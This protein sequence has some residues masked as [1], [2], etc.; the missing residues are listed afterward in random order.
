MINPNIANPQLRKCHVS[1]LNTL[2]MAAGRLSYP[3]L[4]KPSKMPGDSDDKAKYSTAILIP[5]N[6]DISLLH[7]WI[8]KAA[9]GKWGSAV[10]MDKIKL[11]VLDHAE[12]TEDAELAANFPWMIR[13]ASQME[14]A[15]TFPNGERCVTESEVYGGRWARVSVNVFTWEHKLSGRGVSVGLSNVQLLAHDDRLGGGR[16]NVEKE[17]EG[18]F[19]KDDEI[20]GDEQT[21]MPPK[22]GAKDGDSLF[23]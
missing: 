14:P 4:F 6:A 7:D 19:L 18:F 11:P 8:K 12:K 17:F 3:H 9:I 1:P 15:V 2:L 16:V 20:G 21:S 22:G 10:N 5:K 13:C 23:D